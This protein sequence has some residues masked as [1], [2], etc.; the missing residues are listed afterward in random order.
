LIGAARHS[1]RLSKDVHFCAEAKAALETKS[2]ELF[3]RALLAK[4]LAQQVQE[5]QKAYDSKRDQSDSLMENM[6][7][8]KAKMAQ[9]DQEGLELERQLA[10][11]K[12]RLTSGPVVIDADATVTSGGSHS[13]ALGQVEQ[14][15]GMLP[16]EAAQPFAVCIALLKKF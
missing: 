5:L 8:L 11:A 1:Q 16:P 3:Q 13:Q 12:T 7:S 4:P 10:D 15:A 6:K 2:R 14:L 9:V